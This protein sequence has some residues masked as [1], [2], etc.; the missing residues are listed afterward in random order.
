MN[1]PRKLL[2]NKRKRVFALIF[3]PDQDRDPK[4]LSM[5][6]TKGWVML[7]LLTLVA[8]HCVLGFFGYG[9]IFFMT[10]KQH[11]LEEENKDLK[12]QNAKIEQISQ[13]FKKI[14][15]TNEKIRKAFGVSLGLG[16]QGEPD[17][18]TPT[19]GDDRIEQPVFGSPTALPSM[20]S[21]TSPIQNN[22]AFLKERSDGVYNPE[23]L[24]TLLPVQGFLTTHFQQ[25][26]WY[27]GR[28]HNGIDIATAKGTVI[29][30]AGSG[31]VLLS[32][33]TPDFGNVVIIGHGNGFVSYYAHAM[34]LLVEQGNT[35]RRG[36]SI[37]LLGNTGSSSA[38]HL[39]FEI[40]KDGVP[41]NPETFLYAFRQVPAPEGSF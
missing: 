30:S 40:W 20:K 31:T 22:L 5:S 29:R 39:H 1:G 21:S 10:R 23:Y 33:W 2:K 18:K 7:G 28:N 9:K 6:Y 26:D 25:S 27:N 32:N 37:A 15:A 13:D 16:N 12:A 8:V 36:Q 38:P 24:P 17:A 14:L 35:V 11:T 19:S 4:S 41:V 34:R 3:V